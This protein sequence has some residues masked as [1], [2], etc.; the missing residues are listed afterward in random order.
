MKIPAGSGQTYRRN[1]PVR[2]RPTGSS[3]QTYQFSVEN[4]SLFVYIRVKPTDMFGSDLLVSSDQ[5]YRVRVRP[6]G[7]KIQTG[8]PEKE[9]TVYPILKFN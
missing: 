5:T 8:K 1:R 7:N 9:L 6:T 4:R 2:V 3:G